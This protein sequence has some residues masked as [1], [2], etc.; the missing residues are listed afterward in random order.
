MN[1]GYISKKQKKLNLGECG[2]TQNVPNNSEM[3]TQ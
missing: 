3:P 1:N 2:N